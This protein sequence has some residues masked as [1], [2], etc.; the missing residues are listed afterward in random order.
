VWF[1]QARVA[2]L[3]AQVATLQARV[4]RLTQEAAENESRLECMSRVLKLRE[5]EIARLR[6]LLNLVRSPSNKNK[7][8]VAA[9]S[10]FAPLP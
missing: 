6:G 10:H 7:V 4:S 9:S 1:K 8:G 3:E 2:E 5:T